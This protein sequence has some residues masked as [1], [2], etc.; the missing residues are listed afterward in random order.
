MWP[1]LFM[2]GLAQSSGQLSFNS[3]MLAL[4]QYMKTV[5]LN[6]KYTGEVV[7]YLMKYILLVQEFVNDLQKLNLT[8]QEYAYLR[9]LSIFNPGRHMTIS[10]FDGSDANTSLRLISL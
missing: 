1:E 6:K 10:M 3:I 5:I 9:L 7:S 4:I 2:I 8:D